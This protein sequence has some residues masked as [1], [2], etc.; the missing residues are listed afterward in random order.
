[1]P[2][3]M[4]VLLLVAAFPHAAVAQATG[5]DSV[6]V[7]LRQVSVEVDVVVGYDEP[8]LIGQIQL[9]NRLQAAL[10]VE[11]RGAGLTVTAEATPQLVLAVAAAPILMGG[12]VMGV[13]ASSLLKLKDF[14]LSRAA[15]ARSIDSAPGVGASA[16]AWRRAYWDLAGDGASWMVPIW[17]GPLGVALHP[18]ESHR[19]GLER[20][21]VALTRVFTDAF[22]RANPG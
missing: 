9:R 3:S 20:E 12:S 15:V 11:L 17:S 1:M 18:V 10:E 19:E 8:T 7:G 2:R 21:A 22:R 14:A 4:L 6:L 5:Q 13:A 16:M